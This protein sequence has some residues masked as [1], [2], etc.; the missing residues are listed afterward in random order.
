MGAFFVAS[1]PGSGIGFYC[2]RITN[3][4]KKPQLVRSFVSMK[5]QN[6]INGVA[7]VAVVT[8]TVSTFAQ[9]GLK[10]GME[11]GN[12]GLKSV[13]AL[14]FGPEGILFV[15]DPKGARVCAIDLGDH[16]KSSSVASIK[17]VD[18]KV[19]AALG[20][21][22]DGIVIEDLAVDEKT[23]NAYISVS[24]GRGPDAKPALIRIAD[25]KLEVVDLDNV[26]FSQSGLANAPEDKIVGEG[27]RRQNKRTSSITDMAWIDGKI[28][29][30]RT[31]Q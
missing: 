25:G 28:G 2:S 19:A 8:L 5:I 23:Q 6:L 12:P 17:N 18:Q 9:A 26:K 20:T 16:K 10:D 13:G 27:R 29:S 7:I 30:G 21:K 14:T 24:R 3:P 11:E 31:L 1:W 15:A 4:F 22:A